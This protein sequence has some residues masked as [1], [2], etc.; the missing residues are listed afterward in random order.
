K[1]AVSIADLAGAITNK[2]I[3]T[4]FI[5][6]GN[7]VY[8]A[9]ADLEWAKLQG[10]VETVVRLGM[11]VD[12]TAE[13]SHWNVPLAHYLEFWGDGRAADGS[14]VSVQPMILPLFG[15][16]SELDLLAKVAG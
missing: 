3:K 8:N 9:P 15:G 14:Y 1:P 11:E 6:G 10:T 13:V 7:P 2:K 12:E 4:L 5:V 16:W